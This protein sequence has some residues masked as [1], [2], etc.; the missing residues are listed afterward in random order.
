MFGSV[1]SVEAFDNLGELVL[2]LAC[3]FSG[4]PRILTHRTLD[5]VIVVSHKE[6][7]LTDKCLAVYKKLCSDLRIELAPDCPNNDKAFTNQTRGTELG[8]NFNSSPL[9]WSF[10][11]LKA[12]KENFTDSKSYGSRNSRLP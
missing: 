1:N 2:S 9:S 4:F 10:P 11:D 5:D 6:S 3:I 7:G 12:D 8:F